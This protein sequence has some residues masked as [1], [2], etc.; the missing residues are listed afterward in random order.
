MLFALLAV[1]RGAGAEEGVCSP[2]EAQRIVLATF[3]SVLK[4]DVDP[5]ALE[6]VA[7]SQ[8]YGAPDLGTVRCRGANTSRPVVSWEVF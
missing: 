6:V 5:G 1:A 4:R 7:C 2:A 3:T 8:V